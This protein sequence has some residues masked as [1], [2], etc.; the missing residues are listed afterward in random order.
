MKPTNITIEI[1]L[2]HPGESY[3]SPTVLKSIVLTDTEVLETP[4]LR[5]RCL[6]QLSEAKSKLVAY[7]DARQ[8]DEEEAAEQAEE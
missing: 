8:E 2:T 6:A 5:R 4:A 1:K 3:G 7:F